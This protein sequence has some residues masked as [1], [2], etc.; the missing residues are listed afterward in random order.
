MQTILSRGDHD[1]TTIRHNFRN[2][3]LLVFGEIHLQK[4]ACRNTIQLKGTLKK[5]IYL[6]IGGC[7]G[8]K[9]TLSSE[10][11]GNTR[12][13]EQLYTL[14]QERG[15]SIRSLKIGRCVFLKVGTYGHDGD[16]K[17]ELFG[18][19]LVNR[20][21]VHVCSRHV[22][23]LKS[24]VIPDDEGGGS[25]VG[26]GYRGCGKGVRGLEKSGGKRI[27]SLVRL[28]D[29]VVQARGGIRK[30]ERAE[31]G[32]WGVLVGIESDLFEGGAKDGVEAARPGARTRPQALHASKQTCC[33]TSNSTQCVSCRPTRMTPE[34]RESEGKQGQKEG[35]GSFGSC[36]T[37]RDTF[38]A[39]KTSKHGNAL[40]QLHTI[41]PFWTLWTKSGNNT[42]H[43][44]V[45]D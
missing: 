45:G 29:R 38:L 4:R 28:N 13:I 2:Q 23:N 31:M 3:A 5:A 9:R 18:D 25:A 40:G 17:V 11:V 22:P 36:N 10:V 16:G 37:K 39:S 1:P 20:V 33:R 42:Q 32:N 27:A 44:T 21:V 26:T 24:I 8:Q 6:A 19:D 41:N 12:L 14:S 35:K 15:Y 7:Q 30:E 43:M 34:V